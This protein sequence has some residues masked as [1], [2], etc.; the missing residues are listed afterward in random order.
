[1]YRG[2][3][4]SDREGEDAVLR[5][6]SGPGLASESRLFPT[7]VRRP[8]VNE[9]WSPRWRRAD[10]NTEWN[11]TRDP[12]PLLTLRQGRHPFE[13]PTTSRPTV[14]TRVYS[15]VSLEV[16]GVSDRHRGPPEGPPPRL[17]G[18]PHLCQPTPSNDLGGPSVR[19]PTLDPRWID[20]GKV[21][22]TGMCRKWGRRS[23]R[24]RRQ[25]SVPGTT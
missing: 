2:G 9:K 5:F 7:H 12:V 6:V 8:R 18:P 23:P 3:G 16:P 21:R 17:R 4:R 11:P 22:P 15:R 1:M 24:Q 13:G 14:P 19:Y 25:T 10:E 20:Y